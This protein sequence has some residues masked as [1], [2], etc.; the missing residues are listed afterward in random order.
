MNAL[1]RFSRFLRFG[2]FGCFL[3]ATLGLAAC[4]GSETPPLDPPPPAPKEVREPAPSP[5]PA[6]PEEAPATPAA[7]VEAPAAPLTFG[8]II[9]DSSAPRLPDLTTAS[10]RGDQPNQD[11]LP[12]VEGGET[13]VSAYQI[14][15]IGILVFTLPNERAYAFTLRNLETKEEQ[16]YFDKEGDGVFEQQGDSGDVDESAYGY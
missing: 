11:I 13:T 12:T 1:P 7:P 9:G 16:T 4:G 5:Q 6:P 10:R 14:R 2:V 8:D 3:V 15:N